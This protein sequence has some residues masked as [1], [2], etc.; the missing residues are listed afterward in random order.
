MND[1]VT[2]DLVHSI[3]NFPDVILRDVGMQHAN[4]DAFHASRCVA[5]KTFSVS[6]NKL[7]TAR[8]TII[9]TQSWNAC[10][11]ANNKTHF[12]S[13]SYYSKS[14]IYPLL[15][16]H[17][18]AHNRWT[19]PDSVITHIYIRQT[20]AH[21]S[22]HSITTSLVMHHQ[23]QVTHAHHNT[24][25]GITDWLTKQGLYFVHDDYRMDVDTVN[26]V[27]EIGWIAQWR[28]NRHTPRFWWLIDWLIDCCFIFNDAFLTMQVI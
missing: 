5:V 9:R 21:C 16:S 24:E 28:M 12:L 25:A 19:T 22:S 15:N 6:F 11:I 1:R 7:V 3:N 2:P 14:D 10:G 26:T 4:D 27:V 8:I 23:G 18:T 20:F 17:N 13:N